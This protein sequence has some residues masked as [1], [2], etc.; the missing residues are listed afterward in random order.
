MHRGRAASEAGY[1]VNLVFVG[2]PN[3]EVSAARVSERVRDGGHDVSTTDTTRRYPK[4]MAKL[5]IAMSIADCSFIVDNTDRHRLVM[6]REN[7]QSRI[8]G[9]V[10]EWT[11]DAIPP[12]LRRDSARWQAQASEFRQN[13]D[14]LNNYSVGPPPIPMPLLPWACCSASYCRLNSSNRSGDILGNC[15]AKATTPQMSRSS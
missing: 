8:V 15:R 12:E 9:A 14:A 4:T 13:D 6:V 5:P 3:P 7:E 2:I 10:P 11:R 1:K